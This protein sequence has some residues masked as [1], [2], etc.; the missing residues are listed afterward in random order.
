MTTAATAPVRRKLWQ[1]QDFQ[2][3]ILG[4]C[5]SMAEL[6]KLARKL[7]IAFSP[8]ATDYEIHVRFVREASAESPLSHHLNKYLDKKYRTHIRQFAKAQDA[9]TLEAMW[10]FSLKSGDIP[11]PFWAVLSHP[12][13]GAGLRAKVF[14]DVHMLSH[15]MGAA[16]RADIKRVSALERRLDELGQALSRVQAARRSQKLEWT[17]RVKDLEDRLE[18]ERGERLKL[19][20]KLRESVHASGSDPAPVRDAALAAAQEADAAREEA[21]RQAAIIE[22]L[23]RENQALRQ[24]VGELTA[25]LERADNELACALPCA[26]EGC[27]G[28]GCAA[29]SGQC[30]CPELGGKNVLYVGGRCSLVRHYRQLVERAGCRFHHHDGG[31]EHSPG[32]LYGK[33]ASADVVLCPVDCVS[34][35]ACQAVKKACKHCMK[36]FMMLRSSGL[37]AL[38]RS[39]DQLAACVN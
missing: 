26:G 17:V 31:V 20:R 25:E 5:L 23:Y 39:L 2:C 36:P 22:E 29:G 12:G 7:G 24:H 3:P 32:E 11:G 9:A 4:T 27:G 37:S 34:H 35:D 16:N 8:G 33:L 6:R 28:E 13:L 1:Q 14:G 15:L 21:R 30:P 19:A 38:A 18:T 10:K